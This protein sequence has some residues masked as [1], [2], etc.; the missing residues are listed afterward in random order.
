VKL[1]SGGNGSSHLARSLSATDYAFLPLTTEPPLSISVDGVEGAIAFLRTDQEGGFWELFAAGKWEQGNIALIVSLLGPGSTFV[2]VGAWIGPLS[3]IAAKRGARVVAFEPDPVAVEL[4]RSNLALNPDIEP[5]VTLVTKALG[6]RNR[7]SS[8]SSTQLGNS[9]SSLVHKG[10][11]QVTVDM[12]DAKELATEP[13]LNSA[14]VL[15]I[16]I[17]GAEFSVVPRLAWAFQARRPVLLLSV[18]G[19][20]ILERFAT[21]GPRS[22]SVA[23]HAVS[24]LGRARLLFAT[25]AYAERWE[26]DAAS[27]QWQPLTPRSVLSFLFSLQDTELVLSDFEIQ[28][29]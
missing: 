15:K 27:S 18:H 12:I 20:H 4:F 23:R 28:R 22:R 7:S 8:L 13:D 14:D 29:A 24:L 6:T 25:R 16:D 17:E 3:L 1:L 2:D 5:R 19:Y 11:D 26:W 9:M 21:L 10:P